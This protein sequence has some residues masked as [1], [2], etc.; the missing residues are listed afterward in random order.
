M[1][2]SQIAAQVVRHHCDRQ[3]A[4]ILEVRARDLA[5]DAPQR[6]LKLP[7]ARLPRVPADDPLKRA[8][9]E[10]HVVAPHAGIASHSRQQVTP[11]DGELLP[12]VC[13]RSDG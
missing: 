11:R 12:A 8:P 4:A 5:I 9:G 2:F 6:T 3:D 13:S 7:H 1:P 10:A